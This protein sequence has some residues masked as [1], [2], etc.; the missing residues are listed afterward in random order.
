[1]AGA[2]IAVAPTTSARP[3][4]QAAAIDT[5]ITVVAAELLGLIRRMRGMRT[6]AQMTK[7]SS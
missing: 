5:I 3:A 6:V 1:M 2:R 7:L 4:Q